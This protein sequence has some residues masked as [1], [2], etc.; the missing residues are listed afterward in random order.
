[1]EFLW[2]KLFSNGSF[3]GTQAGKAKLSVES[4]IKCPAYLLMFD[5]VPGEHA[6]IHHIFVGTMVSQGLEVSSVDRESPYP[7][8]SVSNY[9]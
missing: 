7:V 5:Q 2:S 3:R 6:N 8:S 1:M 9:I 4:H